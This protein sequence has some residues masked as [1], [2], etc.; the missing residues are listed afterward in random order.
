MNTEP[1]RSWL[2]LR[3]AQAIVS[4]LLVVLA[5]YVPW[6]TAAD[7]AREGSLSEATRR[8]CA[9]HAGEP[10]LQVVAIDVDFHAEPPLFAQGEGAVVVPVALDL[11]GAQRVLD[12][13]SEPGSLRKLTTPAITALAWEYGGRLHREMRF[14]ALALVDR[15]AL[16]SV[17]PPDAPTFEG[18]PPDLRPEAMARAVDLQEHELHKCAAFTDWARKAA[19]PPPYTTQIARLVAAVSRRSEDKTAAE[20]LCAALRDGL[21]KP[22]WAQVAVVM[23]ARE[24]GVPAYGFASATD[25]GTHL[26]GT[27]LDGTGWILMDVDRVADGWF[28]GGPALVTMSPLLGGFSASKHDFWHPEAAAYSSGPWGVQAISSTEWRGTQPGKR[29]DT[30]AARAIPL[31][32]ACR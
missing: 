8:W 14:R 1:R 4:L 26:V 13:A 32:E 25:A 29:T 2:A 23:G 9:A 16:R 18:L 24:L 27:Y 21:F 28:T 5:G 7:V 15:P 10:D 11:A 31:A 12:V 3:L 30:T 6:R 22:H 17:T 19:G 20:D